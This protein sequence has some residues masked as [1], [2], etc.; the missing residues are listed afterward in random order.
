MAPTGAAKPASLGRV[1]AALALVVVAQWLG[2]SLWFSPSGAADGLM[3]HLAID[4]VAF[5]WLIAATQLGF[6]AGTFGFASTGAADRFAASRIFTASCILGAAANAAL[7]VP[8]VDFAGAWLLRFAVGPRPADIEMHLKGTR[9][10]TNSD[11]VRD[12][13][14]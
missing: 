14:G 10:T 8:G 11:R 3:K 2:T 13:G 1:R 7:V 5:A 4:A 6:I 9:S 12:A